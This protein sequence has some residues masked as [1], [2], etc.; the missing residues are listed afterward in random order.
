MI[1]HEWVCEE[2]IDREWKGTFVKN[3]VVTT[4]GPEPI[5]MARTRSWDADRSAGVL[6]LVHGLGQ[7]R[8]AWHLPQRSPANYLAS[9]GYDVFAVD[10]RGHGRSRDLGARKALDVAEHVNEDIPAAVQEALRVSGSTHLFLVGHSLGGLLAYAAAPAL[11]S[12]VRG[13][14]SLGSPYYFAAGQPGLSKLGDA[15]LWLDRQVGLGHTGV[16]LYPVGQAIRLGR[17]LIESRLAPIPFRGYLPGSIEDDVLSEHMTRAMDFANFDVMRSLFRAGVRQRRVGN[18][19]G[20]ED[21]AQAFEQ[22][23]TPLLVIAG[24]HDD[25]APPASVRPAYERS[26]SADKTYRVV[27]HG[28]LDM[29]VGRFAPQTTWPVLQAWLGRRAGDG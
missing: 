25:L 5:A 3:L 11:G 17:F 19:G 29:L 4:Q 2:S 22:L 7:N 27:S 10:L 13:I 14:V 12:L 21:Y 20:L 8:R 6:L 15:L 18:I 16:G 1:L 24:R 26:R 9:V 28:H 23:P